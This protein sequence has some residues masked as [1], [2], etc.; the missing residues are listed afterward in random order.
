[1]CA[2]P[3]ASRVFLPQNHRVN[4]ILLLTIAA[5]AIGSTST[6]L[7][8]VTRSCRCCPILPM[9]PAWS[10]LATVAGGLRSDI[11]WGDRER[12]Q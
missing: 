4:L 12:K 11:N 1:M 3:H 7:V 10:S 2:I 9:L 5:A 6:D 8:D